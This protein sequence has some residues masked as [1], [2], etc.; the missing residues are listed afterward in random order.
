[1]AKRLSKALDYAYIDTGALYRAVGL[2]ILRAGIDPDDA[3]AVENGLEDAKISF[4]FED[5]VQMTCLNGEDVSGLIR[6][7]EVSDY[8]SRT[9]A[10]PCVRAALLALQQDFAKTHS[11]IMDGRDI[12]TTVLPDAK[13]KIYLTASAEARA[14]R[15]YKELIERGEPVEYADVLADMKERDTRDMSRA[16]SPLRRAPD[17]IEVDTTH[18]DIEQ[19]FDA[20]LSTS[21]ER[22]E[23]L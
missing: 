23:T 16:I 20:L 22:L 6:T 9:S 18:L 8:A 17:A 1:M 3:Q 10:L 15:R 11:L 2:Y 21:R 4:S 7:P 12:G 14:E 13:I 19:T 5:G